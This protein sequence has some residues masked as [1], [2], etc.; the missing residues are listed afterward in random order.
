MTE[1][2]PVELYTNS[3]NVKDSIGFISQLSRRWLSTGE[4]RDETGDE[5][6]RGGSGERGWGGGVGG[7]SSFR[8]KLYQP[9]I[10]RQC[11]NK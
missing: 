10:M 11:W 3:T 4:K 8:R 6:G 1:Q 5:S 2:R 9:F 7:V